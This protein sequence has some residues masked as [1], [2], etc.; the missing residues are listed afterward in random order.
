MGDNFNLKDNN[1]QINI[2]KDNACNVLKYGRSLA[3]NS[4]CMSNILSLA[5]SAALVVNAKY[6]ILLSGV[7]SL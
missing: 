6:P 7:P 1:G 3:C 5:S 4:L 2:A